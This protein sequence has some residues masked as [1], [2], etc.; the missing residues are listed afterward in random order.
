ML[1]YIHY[2]FAVQ[3]TLAALV[4]AVFLYFQWAA[5]RRHRQR[6]FELLVSST[7]CAFGILAANAAMLIFPQTESSYAECVVLAFG[8][9][10][11]QLGFCL[12]G[13]ILLFRDYRTLAEHY[14]KNS[15]ARMPGDRNE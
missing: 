13:T 15:A 14:E 10:V 9:T 7:L 2:L 11:G 8:F 5:M 12:A 3:I 6:S 1:K 4:C